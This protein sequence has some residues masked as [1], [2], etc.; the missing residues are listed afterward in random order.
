MDTCS[1]DDQVF[2]PLGN[3]F[4]FVKLTTVIT[5][6]SSNS[7]KLI[8]STWISYKFYLNSSHFNMDRL[9]L[10]RIHDRHLY[11]PIMHGIQTLLMKQRIIDNRQ[12]RVKS[13]KN[14]KI[15]SR[16]KL[17]D[18]AISKLFENHRQHNI[19][20]SQF[21]K[22]Q[23]KRRVD[24]RSVIYNLR[25]EMYQHR[26]VNHLHVLQTK[27]I[28]PYINLKFQNK[29]KNYTTLRSKV[30]LENHFSSLMFRNSQREHRQ[31]H[32]DENR[33]NSNKIIKERPIYQ[34]LDLLNPFNYRFKTQHRVENAKYRIFYFNV[35]R[36]NYDSINTYKLKKQKYISNE[37]KRQLTYRNRILF[38]KKSDVEIKNSNEDN[39][40][41]NNIR[42]TLRLK[43]EQILRNRIYFKLNSQN[44]QDR[45]LRMKHRKYIETFRLQNHHILSMNESYNRKIRLVR[46]RAQR[47]S[48]INRESLF[49]R[50]EG[51][52]RIYNTKLYNSINIHLKA[53]QRNFRISN[54]IQLQ[55]NHFENRKDKRYNLI[56]TIRE[57][58]QKNRLTLYHISGSVFQKLRG[59]SNGILQ[60]RINKKI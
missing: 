58:D 13:V 45:G 32:S 57:N 42:S 52:Q 16:L 51:M 30:R 6:Q 53:K 4:S 7:L 56:L 55:K 43:Y 10:I 48:K 15:N 3:S 22:A 60:V 20:P 47:I 50:R 33:F 36:Q 18:P 19:R 1:N 2:Y 35:Q 5:T 59:I 21:N 23:E 54:K 37:I 27:R 25:K 14:H 31:I 24:L 41:N 34:L 28:L 12:N 46:N 40:S 26:F 11:A 49:S 44:I 29:Q 8:K 17:R 9:I 39:H 38:N